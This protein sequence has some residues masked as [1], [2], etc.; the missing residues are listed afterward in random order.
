MGGAARIENVEDFARVAQ[1]LSDPFCATPAERA[2][3]LAAVALD[4]AGWEE[5]RA[6]YTDKL[7]KAAATRNV[8][9][10]VRYRAAFEAARDARHAGAI[11]A[12]RPQP[13]TESAPPP[14]P[15][16]VVEAP[17]DP[18][19]TPSYLRPE[20]SA[21][22]MPSHLMGAPLRSATPAP[23]SAVPELA[24]PTPAPPVA[25]AMVAAPPPAAVAPPAL[26]QIGAPGP[27][28]T[29]PRPGMDGTALLSGPLPG[30]REAMSLP[31]KA[32]TGSS[33]SARPATTP[34]QGSSIST[35][36][37]MAPEGM[38]I[39]S[40]PFDGAKRAEGNLTGWTVERYAEVCVD[41]SASGRTRAE[42]LANHGLDEARFKTL[43]A[44]WEST[45]A[46]DP[47]LQSKWSDACA[48]RKLAFGIR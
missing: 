26:I 15:A 3:V 47:A 4:E 32:G 48:R 20:A 46:D 18:A 34:R 13:K 21:R 16:P 12:A 41:L 42:V 11:Q 2:A 22:A 37:R 19:F 8:D 1:Q 40:L 39:R 14:A 35:G 44:Y 9:V 29:S 5:L 31:F 28:A 30:V 25:P 43:D 38:P 10:C 17:R 23:M 45:I 36:T 33:P 7:A 24:P 27:Q 6:A